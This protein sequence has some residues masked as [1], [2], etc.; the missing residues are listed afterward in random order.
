MTRTLV[1]TPDPEPERAP[2]A[3]TLTPPTFSTTATTTSSTIWV[4]PWSVPA[5]R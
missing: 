4:L 1:G 3:W 2:N 5:N